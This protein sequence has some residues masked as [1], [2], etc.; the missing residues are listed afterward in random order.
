MI[1]F[2]SLG[3]IYYVHYV[4]CASFKHGLKQRGPLSPPFFSHNRNAPVETAD[5]RHVQPGANAAGRTTCAS[6]LPNRPAACMKTRRS[7]PS[8]YECSDVICSY[9]QTLPLSRSFGQRLSRADAP[10]NA[11]YTRSPYPHRQPFPFNAHRRRSCVANVHRQ[12]YKRRRSPFLETTELRTRTPKRL[13]TALRTSFPAS[14]FALE[15][16]TKSSLTRHRRS[17]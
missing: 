17:R 10:S 12:H 1:F 7:R 9:T 11:L 3:L 6:S 4:Y 15:L 5:H 14:F 2:L 8:H 16:L 13:L